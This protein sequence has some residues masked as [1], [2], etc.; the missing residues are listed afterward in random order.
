MRGYVRRWAI[1]LGPLVAL[2]LWATMPTQGQTG[3]GQTWEWKTYGAD[4]RSTRYAP[5]DQINATNFN[6]LEVAWRFKTDHLGP[7]PEFQLQGTP[8]FIGG[9]MV[10]DRWN[11]SRGGGA[12]RQD[13]R[14]AL[15]AQPE[16]RQAR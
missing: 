6:K 15:D 13:R 7:R 9:R 8:L 4:L 1:G 10:R 14:A 16:R 11:A 3:G 2:L 5:L 12:R